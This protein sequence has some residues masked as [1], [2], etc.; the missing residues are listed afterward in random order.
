MQTQSQTQADTFT[1]NNTNTYT[2]HLRRPH[3][4][5]T[6]Q[7][8]RQKQHT[9][10]ETVSKL[11]R[12]A[13]LT[14]SSWFSLSTCFCGGVCVAEGTVRKSGVTNT[15]GSGR[16]CTR[17]DSPHDMSMRACSKSSLYMPP[18]YVY[19]YMYIHTHIYAYK[20][21]CTHTSVQTNIHKH[22][23]IHAY[24]TKHACIHSYKHACIHTHPYRSTKIYK[25]IHTYTHT[26][27][28]PYMHMH[29][30][31]QCVSKSEFWHV[32]TAI[33]VCMRK[34]SI[35]TLSIWLGRSLGCSMA[36]Y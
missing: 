10:S 17:K 18:I 1:H 15:H 21:T 30:Q 19:I 5:N 32:E 22:A 14:F 33:P 23:C 4:T 12:C 13:F 26:T 16:A 28:N 8:T 20:H 27:C 9:A 25:S 24:I 34:Q 31:D 11:R 2:P 35:S 29:T 3:H 7:E 36:I 6:Q